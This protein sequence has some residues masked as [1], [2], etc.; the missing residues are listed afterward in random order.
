[1]TALPTAMHNKMY[2]SIA[3]TSASQ[4]TTQRF[5]IFYSPPTQDF[6][7]RDTIFS[8]PEVIFMHAAENLCAVLTQST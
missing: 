3:P 6:Q 1:M 8:A 2:I 5:F 7:I 4:N